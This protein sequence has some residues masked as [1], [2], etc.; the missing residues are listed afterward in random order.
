V[1]A[2]KTSVSALSGTKSRFQNNDETYAGAMPPQLSAG[3][4]MRISFIFIALILSFLTACSQSAN[5][6]A[7]H[8]PP[9]DGTW[10]LQISQPKQGENAKGV[11][12]TLGSSG[13]ANAA[14]MAKGPIFYRVDISERQGQISGCLIA[15]SDEKGQAEVSQ[16]PRDDGEERT[17]RWE[18]ANL[19]V[20]MMSPGKGSFTFELKPVSSHF[21]GIAKVKIAQ[22]PI[23][24]VNAGAVMFT[25]IAPLSGSAEKP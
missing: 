17:C 8:H 14:S 11:S 16:Q 9:V 6:K 21:E 12:V 18:G 20:E 5:E 2:T 22:L 23:G 10:L 3:V 19:I 15:S 7:I 13:P 4:M 24:S 1:C 25:R